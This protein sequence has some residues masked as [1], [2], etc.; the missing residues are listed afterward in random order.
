[1]RYQQSA[2]LLSINSS[3]YIYIYRATN[4]NQT[5]LP[6]NQSSITQNIC[7]SST[8]IPRPPCRSTYVSPDKSWRQ[9]TQCRMSGLALLA[10]CFFPSERFVVAAR[11]R[12]RPNGNVSSA[13][14][15]GTWVCWLPCFFLHVPAMKEAVN[16][17]E[18]GCRVR[19]IN[20]YHNANRMK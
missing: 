12:G 11:A 6:N 5:L 16:S 3:M 9:M 14:E 17:V 13:M 8:A 19:S 18:A 7:S 15:K 4:H 10:P 2:R 1:M 20:S